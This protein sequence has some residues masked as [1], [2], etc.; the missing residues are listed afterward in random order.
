MT[1]TLPPACEIEVIPL[2]AQTPLGALVVFVAGE[3]LI[4]HRLVQRAGERW[5]TQ[6]DGALAA[7]APLA[8][9]Q[10]LGIVAAAYRDGQRCWPGRAERGLAWA[11][12]VRYHALRPL[13]QAWRVVRRWVGRVGAGLPV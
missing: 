1:P 3:R 5:V 8:P 12:I 13:R 4:A 6:G 9:A 10:L 11:W 2:P 7:D